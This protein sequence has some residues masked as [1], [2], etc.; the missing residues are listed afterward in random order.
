M[1]AVSA[2]VVRQRYPL[3]TAVVSFYCDACGRTFTGAEIKASQD[4]GANLSGNGQT[5]LELL[6]WAGADGWELA[7]R[8]ASGTR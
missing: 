1:R 6:N 5:A 4:L 3:M 7:D 2:L 8:G